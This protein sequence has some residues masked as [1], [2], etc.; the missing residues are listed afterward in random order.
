MHTITGSTGQGEPRAARNAGLSLALLLAIN[1]FNYIDRQV[2]AAVEPNISRE[3]FPEGSDRGDLL[4]GLLPSA[5]MVSYMLSAPVF[6][7]L[8]DRARRWALI[9]VGVIVWSVASGGSGLATGIVMLLI[10]RMFVGIGEG[11]YGPAAPTIIS[12]LF[13]V[14]SRG[15]KLAWFYLAIPVGSALGYVLG[16]SITNATGNWRWAF[17]SVVAPGIVL[18]LLCFFMREPA[19]G[20]ADAGSQHRVARIRDVKVLLK[21]PSYVWATLG[22]TA[23]TFAVGGIGFWMPRYVAVFRMGADVGT[24]EG[25][26]TLAS[27]NF[28]FGAL[29]VVAGLLGTL[30]GG[31]LGDRLRPRLPGS[32]FT[33]SGLGMIAGFPLFLLSMYRPFPEAWVYIFLAEF[34]LFFNTGPTNTILANVTHPSIRASA[35]AITILMIHLF[36]DASSPF[37]MPLVKY[38][39]GGSWN[40]AFALVAVAFLVAGVFWLLGAKH[41]ERDT[42]LAPTRLGGETS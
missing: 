39:L 8:A 30:A 40:T 34:C 4:M 1:L 27:V 20:Q 9:G 33:I 24:S 17:Y 35:F 28:T 38:M 26:R 42:R 16:G 41:L 15:R 10:T 3:F 12:D 14:S 36:G 21:T 37:L 22:M 29:T 25:Q 5:F 18:G 2:L 11:A 19:R 13:P 32:Y 6:G 31:F 23:M 7:W